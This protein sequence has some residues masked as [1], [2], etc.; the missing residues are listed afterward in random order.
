MDIKQRIVEFCDYLWEIIID[1]YNIILRKKC[2]PQ[3][4]SRQALSLA[5]DTL[6]IFM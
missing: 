2:T 1:I 3:V 4:N 6:V 5:L